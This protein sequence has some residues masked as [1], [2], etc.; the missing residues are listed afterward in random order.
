MIKY[1]YDYFNYIYKYIYIYI[2]I[3]IYRLPPAPILS[4]P[5]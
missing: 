3:N 1:I 2:Y 5:M 4:V